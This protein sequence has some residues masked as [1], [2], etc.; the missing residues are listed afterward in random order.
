[1]SEYHN[2]QGYES[3][4]E[5]VEAVM[6]L[7]NSRPYM[8]S[9]QHKFFGSFDSYLDW[10]RLLFEDIFF[11][12]GEE[13]DAGGLAQ[14]DFRI[15]HVH[16]QRWLHRDRL[17]NVALMIHELAE[18]YMVVNDFVFW[19][20]YSHVVAEYFEGDFRTERNLPSC[21]VSPLPLDLIPFMRRFECELE[22]KIGAM[23]HKDVE[24]LMD[25]YPALKHYAWKRVIL[26]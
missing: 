22:Q 21:S 10:I 3:I 18:G 7:K 2:L 12:N 14:E 16:R 19:S 11:I 8:F 4:D 9:R 6:W 1:M 24:R 23:E 20:T 5:V 25:M 17:S 13:T 26:V 15:L